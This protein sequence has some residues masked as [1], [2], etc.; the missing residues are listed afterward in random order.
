MTDVG[1]DQE[2][3]W[4]PQG[5]DRKTTQQSYV[6]DCRWGTLSEAVGGHTVWGGVHV[7]VHN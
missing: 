5:C 2:E 3:M 6:F 7:I 4:R 1:R